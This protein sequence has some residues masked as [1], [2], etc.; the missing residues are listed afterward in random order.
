M[1]DGALGPPPE[2]RQ[3][4]PSGDTED[5]L[6]GSRSRT[7]M[8]RSCSLVGLSERQRRWLEPVLA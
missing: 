5:R 8:I 2:C 1:G 3:P 6:P 7:R 4:S